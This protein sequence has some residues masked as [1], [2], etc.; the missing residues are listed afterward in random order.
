MRLSTAQSQSTGIAHP[1][2]AVSQQ[3]SKL[4]P[5][6]T[7]LRLSVNAPLSLKKQVFRANVFKSRRVNVVT[8][9]DNSKVTLIKELPEKILQVKGLYLF[10]FVRDAFS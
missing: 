9:I 2:E 8:E 3:A 1:H 4:L 5:K 10:S 6:P 7:L